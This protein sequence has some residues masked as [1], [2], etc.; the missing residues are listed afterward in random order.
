MSAKQ[1]SIRTKLVH[2]VADMALAI[3][4][5]LCLMALATPALVQMVYKEDIPS[6]YFL[7]AAK[8]TV[9]QT[10]HLNKT[11]ITNE[12]YSNLIWADGMVDEDILS[13]AESMLNL[14]PSGIADSMAADGWTVHV[15]ASGDLDEMASRSK[16]DNVATCLGLTVYTDKTIYIKASTEGALEATL[17]EVGHYVDRKLGNASQS[18]DFIAIYEAEKGSYSDISSYGSSSSAELFASIFDD[19]SRGM[20]SREAYASE[21]WAYIDNAVKT[22]ATDAPMVG[23]IE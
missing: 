5:T 6:P 17:H 22:F 14:L 1:T 7:V 23:G 15:T 4:I 21:A 12:Q 8:T 9:A 3:F 10:V 19:Y 16:I 18:D 11:Y 2:I 13:T 20:R